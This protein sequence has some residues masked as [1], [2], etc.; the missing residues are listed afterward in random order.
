MAGTLMD[1][2]IGPNLVVNRTRRFMA[3][4]WRVVERRA[5]YLARWASNAVKRWS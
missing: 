3:S 4:T 2:H 1:F 5:G